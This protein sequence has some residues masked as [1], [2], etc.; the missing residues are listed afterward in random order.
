MSASVVREGEVRA[1]HHSAHSPGSVMPTYLLQDSG[2]YIGLLQHPA[3]NLTAGDEVVLADGRAARVTARIDSW[4]GSRFAA[5]LDIRVLP[6]SEDPRRSR[7]A[8]DG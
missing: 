2:G 7:Q 1:V 3:P 8:P 4:H 6:A 5:V